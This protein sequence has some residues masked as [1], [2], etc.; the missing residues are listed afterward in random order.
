MVVLRFYQL[1]VFLDMLRCDLLDGFN[2]IIKYTNATIHSGQQTCP[3]SGAFPCKLSPMAILHTG[4][5]S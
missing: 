3:E 4:P 2:N 5:I 1:A